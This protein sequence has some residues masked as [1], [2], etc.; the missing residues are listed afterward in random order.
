MQNIFLGHTN[1]LFLHFIISL[2]ISF[3]DLISY[4]VYSS[5]LHFYI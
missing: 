4:C 5:L 1:I 2:H 3:T